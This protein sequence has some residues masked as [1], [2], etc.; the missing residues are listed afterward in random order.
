MIR[1]DKNC[2]YQK[3]IKESKNS[4]IL[5]VN[6]ALL[7]SNVNKQDSF[8]NEQNICIIDEAHKFVEN[9]RGQHT[10]LLNLNLLKLLYEDIVLFFNK[11]KYK[12]IPVDR[13][14]IILKEFNSLKNNL[15]EFIHLYN[16]FSNEF[17]DYLLEKRNNLF[18]NKIDIKYNCNESEFSHLSIQP[19]C[20]IDLLNCPIFW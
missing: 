11:I 14:E 16:E 3:V 2:F 20:L 4:N 10:E 19:K 1:Q 7:A 12:N 6:H 5:V 9:C 15:E 13:V 18:N 8:I 17:A